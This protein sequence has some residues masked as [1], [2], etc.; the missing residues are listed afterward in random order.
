[1][2]CCGASVMLAGADRGR[3]EVGGSLE[4][5]EMLGC[6][7]SFCFCE[8][9]S[10]SFSRTSWYSCSTACSC[11]SYSLDTPPDPVTRTDRCHGHDG[12][13]CLGVVRR[14]NGCPVQQQLCK[15][16]A[17]PT[18]SF[19]ERKKRMLAKDGCPHIPSVPSLF[20]IKGFQMSLRSCWPFRFHEV[21]GRLLIWDT[22][23]CSSRNLVKSTREQYTPW[24]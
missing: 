24:S 16:A 15:A 8:A 18:Q 10:T 11:A 5:R 2:C 22:H 3:E 14:H 21:N 7:A 4:G 20:Q 6:W 12:S 1:M 17:N 23:C 9:L 13:T 19:Q